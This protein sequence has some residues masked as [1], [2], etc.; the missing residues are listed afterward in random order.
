MGSSIEQIYEKMVV[1]LTCDNIVTELIESGIVEK[2]AKLL[3]AGEDVVQEVYLKIL[4]KVG[5]HGQE[6]LDD[7]RINGNLDG[8]VYIMCRNVHYDSG[9]KEDELFD[10]RADVEDGLLPIED[11][12]DDIDLLHV[13]DSYLLSRPYER[14][15]LEGWLIEGSWRK[16]AQDIR[17]TTG[18]TIS[19]QSLYHSYKKLIIELTEHLEEKGYKNVQGMWERI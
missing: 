16:L 17:C 11:R 9:F 15:V 14:M 18:K 1:Y 10:E 12:I 8:Y 4:L 6:W 2:C 7:K 5:R 13:I 19:H 3:G